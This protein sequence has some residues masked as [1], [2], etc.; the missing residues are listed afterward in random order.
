MTSRTKNKISTNLGHLIHSALGGSR[1]RLPETDDEVASAESDL[2]A[3][4]SALPARL[5]DPM[6]FLNAP[7][8]GR[9]IARARDASSGE[10]EADL[11]RAAREGGQV[12][13]EVDAKMRA[14]RLKAEADARDTK[15]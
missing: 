5:Q 10:V 4:P 9:V 6:G 2:A 7:A 1:L 11:A 3:S 8:T 13:S 12:S 14:D 15:K